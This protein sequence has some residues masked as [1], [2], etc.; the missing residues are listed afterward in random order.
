MN[1][2]KY[3]RPSFRPYIPATGIMSIFPLIITLMSVFLPAEKDPA[4]L[5]FFNALCWSMALFPTI[6][7]MNILREYKNSMKR[8]G[9]RGL[10]NES[11]KDFEWAEPFFDDKIR[12]GLKFIFFKDEGVIL[13]V[14]DIL[15]MQIGR[16][17]YTGDKRGEKWAYFLKTRGVTR[18][19]YSGTMPYPSD[20][21]RLCEKLTELEPSIYVHEKILE[22][23]QHV[24]LN[25]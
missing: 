19:V 10:V 7:Y 22:Q 16:L 14:D 9:E 6:S 8:L 11:S 21:E 3:L 5:V 2:E 1:F 20:W 15:E 4:G 18:I 24:D 25:S 13:S 23:E 17:T 12:V